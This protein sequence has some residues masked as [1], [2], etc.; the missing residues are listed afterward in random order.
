MGRII[1]I[2][3]GTT[4][5]VAAFMEGTQPR[6]IPNDRGNH[7]TPS[8]VAFG[9]SGEVLVGES[10][11]NQAVVNAG[12]T[13]VHVKRRMGQNQLIDIDGN[14]YT[15]QQISA[16]ILKKVRQDAESFLGTEVRQAVIAV[17]AHFSDKQRKATVEAGRLAGLTVLRIINEPTAAALAYG[18]R[19]GDN[20]RILVYDLGGGTFDATCLETDGTT[21][22]V[23]ASC[24]DNHLGGMDID[25][26][27]MTEALAAFSEQ[28][29][30]DMAADPLLMQQLGEMIERVKIELSSR[31]SAS[32]ALPFYVAGGKPLH[33]QYSL[34]RDR[35]E[36]LVSGLLDRSIELTL[37]AV[38]HSGFDRTGIDSLVLS[39]GSSRIPLVQRRL[40]EELGV[41][42]VALVNPDEIV[43]LGAAVQAEML[44]GDSQLIQL[45]DV[46][47]YTLGVEIDNGR[48]V[49]LVKKQTQ[50]PAETRRVFTTVTDNQNAVEIHVLQGEHPDVS[51]NHSLGRFLLSG[52]REGARGEPRI[53]VTFSVDAGGM[54]HVT[55]RDKDTGAAQRITVHPLGD[56]STAGA[57]QVERRLQ[58]LVA[59]IRGLKQSAGAQL[60][61]GFAREIDDLLAHAE[62]SVKRSD[63]KT[64]RESL[65][66]L[67]TLV[68]ELVLMAQETEADDAGA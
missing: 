2:D 66:A 43:A 26:L 51:S 59:R 62:R 47:S 52:I 49:D 8:V 56:D 16:L 39:G 25:A 57:D 53:E 60:D 29:G 23:T 41:R 11:R 20:A 3:L 32:L 68:D 18:A 42:E 9:N 27:L 45:H 61:Q 13:V 7:L 40:R 63:H 67:E 10:A 28:A 50:I 48:F 35:F 36:H 19:G 6:V 33:L 38:N 34:G 1:G 24:G 64:M 31:D 30:F 15:P 65:I 55:A 37:Q 14:G 17:P 5:T 12:R 22:T 4:N 46:V 44:A 21:F 58:A 54:A